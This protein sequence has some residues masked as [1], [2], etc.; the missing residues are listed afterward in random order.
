VSTFRRPTMEDVAARAGVGRGTVSRVI[1]ESPRVSDAARLAVQRAI[2]ALGYAPS[3]AARA[4][5]TSRTNTVALVLRESPGRRYDDAL[6]GALLRAVAAGLADG[7]LR[8]WP[9]FAGA[10]GGAEITERLVLAGVDGVMVADAPRDDPLLAE[11]AAHGV[12]AV[13]VG[14]L[15]GDVDAHG[16]ALAAGMRSALGTPR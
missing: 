13:A 6:V 12:V 4:L 14:Q 9:V 10:A 2:A 5:A 7:A 3:A 8:C 11:L 16:H 15:A 1:N